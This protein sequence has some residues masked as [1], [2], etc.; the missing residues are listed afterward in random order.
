MLSSAEAKIY[1]R[2]NYRH[3]SFQPSTQIYLDYFK[4]FYNLGTEPFATED[5]DWKL[6]TLDRRG[7]VLSV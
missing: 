6:E 7:I 2:I 3:W 4:K 1:P 5:D